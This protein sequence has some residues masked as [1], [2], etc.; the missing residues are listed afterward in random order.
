[1]DRREFLKTLGLGGIALSVPKPLELMAARLA[2]VDAP[3]IHAGLCRF[4]DVQGFPFEGIGVVLDGWQKAGLLTQ[5]QFS[6]LTQKWTIHGGVRV[7]KDIYLPLFRQPLGNSIFGMRSLGDFAS[8]NFR[9][10]S[11]ES[12]DVWIVPE[13]IIRFPLPG[14]TVCMYGPGYPPPPWP[15]CKGRPFASQPLKTVRLERARAIELGLVSAAEP[16]EI[17]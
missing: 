16:F 15:E 13:G 2:K 10:M 7:S 6:E 4:R 12:V 17:V 14:L 9:I 8:R 11:A 3:P 5:E 1:M